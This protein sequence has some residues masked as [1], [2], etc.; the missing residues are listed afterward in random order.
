MVGRNAFWGALLGAMLASCDLEQLVQVQEVVTTTEGEDTVT[1]T[2]SDTSETTPDSTDT[3]PSSSPTSDTNTSTPPAPTGPWAPAARADFFTLVGESSTDVDVGALG[4]SAPYLE[5]D[6]GAFS[7]ESDSPAVLAGT[8]ATTVPQ[9]SG[10]L[11]PQY[12]RHLGVLVVHDFT[13][14][15]GVTL[16]VHG[17][18]PLVIAASGDIVIEGIID[19]GA[20]DIGQDNLGGERWMQQ[21]G[22]G[23]YDGSLPVNDNAFAHGP[24]AGVTLD[25]NAGSGA[26]Y[27]NRGGSA[28]AD[29]VPGGP[30]AWIA[31]VF[32]LRGGAG[33]GVGANGNTSHGS[34]GGGG[35]ALYL[36]AQGRIVI[37]KA[38]DAAGTSGLHA[39]G[40]GGD[41]SP[42]SDGRGAGG[43]AG[44]TLVLDA[45]EVTVYGTLAANGGGGSA[46]GSHSCPP[47][48]QGERGHFGSTAAMGGTA[49]DFAT[50]SELGGDGGTGD[51]LP[52]AGGHRAGGG[53][54]AG[55][56]HLRGETV[57][58]DSGATLSP[59]LATAGAVV[60]KVD[61]P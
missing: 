38:G 52:R 54:S 47:G 48:C 13:V 12:V 14:P 57:T 22:P 10:L 42:G 46:R 23:G 17:D 60:E 56:I 16:R 2:V 30:A 18:L 28:H 15:A 24:G 11:L 6:T 34:G 9:E 29:A 1:Q 50:S 43:G 26:G 20:I 33:G 32:P 45:P 36:V 40:G 61:A 27:L 55:R 31:S 58:V 35:G 53:G 3:T 4:L 21:G 51:I 59:S 5:S 25:D 19:A 8:L 37:G 41:R 7:D 49:Y 44:G 39:P